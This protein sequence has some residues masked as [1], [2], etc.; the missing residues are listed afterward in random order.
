MIFNSKNISFSKLCEIMHDNGFKFASHTY[1]DSFDDIKDYLNLKKPD[2]LAFK[3]NNS[4][5]YFSP[6]INK[7]TT[8]WME[9]S[10]SWT[11]VCNRNIIFIK[12]KKLNILNS[13]F[14]IKSYDKTLYK[15]YCQLSLIK[16]N[17]YFYLIQ[18][19]WKKISKNYDGLYYSASNQKFSS[20]KNS[21]GDMWDVKTLIIWNFNCIKEIYLFKSI[22]KN[23]FSTDYNL[24]IN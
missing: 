17:E 15:L 2:N 7:K 22:G 21:F 14:N 1:F 13:K 23:K 4:K 8:E 20:L 12:Y 5:L 19:N 16:Q 11:D 9:F 6:I 18:Y 3:P 10:K 24:I